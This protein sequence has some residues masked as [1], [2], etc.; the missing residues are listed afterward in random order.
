MPLGLFW[1]L[2][3]DALLPADLD[4]DGRPRLGIT[5]PALPLARRMWAG[6]EVRFLSPSSRRTR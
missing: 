5:L 4:R 2:S 3:P 1:A 6:G